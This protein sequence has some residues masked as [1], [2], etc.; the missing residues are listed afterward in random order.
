MPVENYFLLL[1]ALL[2][3]VYAVLIQAYGNWFRRLKEFI[4]AA[5]QN[6]LTHFSIIIPARNEEQNIGACIRAIETGSYPRD[7]FEIIVADDFSTDQTAR[8]VMELHAEF[9]NIRLLRLEEIVHSKINSYKKKS[10]ESAI[11]VSANEWIVTTDADCIPPPRWLEYFDACIRKDDPV[12]IAAPVMFLNDGSLL[13][14]FQCLDFI[15]LQGI[16][17]ASVSAGFH[18][19]CNGAN[20]AYRKS[21]F[22]EVGGFRG[23]DQLASGDDMLLMHKIRQQHPGRI[24]YVFSKAVIVR[25]LPMPDWKS[26]INQRL[27]WAS[28]ATAYTDK[29]IFAVLLLVYFVNLLIL[30]QLPLGLF[31]PGF[32]F[33]FLI[34]CVLKGLV[35]F[36]FMYAAAGF[37]DMRNCLWWFIPMQPLHILYT[38]I[39]GFFGK[40]GKYTWKGRS[41]Q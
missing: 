14:V 26:F 11:A 6:P 7:L 25:T 13:S 21:V 4:P 20:L 9:G 17:A 37:F 10:I 2:L 35:E 12:F 1:S 36:P 33:S 27:R 39:S 40:F 23:I 30:L 3:C 28:K 15:S 19:M 22:A 18:S 34:C 16:T 24:A 31:Y 29:K 8:V 32:F 5:G 41:V 38:V